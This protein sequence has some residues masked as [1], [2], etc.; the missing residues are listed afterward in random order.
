MVMNSKGKKEIKFKMPE[1]SK[2][3]CLVGKWNCKA[4]MLRRG[5]DWK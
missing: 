4:G 5:V 1:T 3:G 2:Y